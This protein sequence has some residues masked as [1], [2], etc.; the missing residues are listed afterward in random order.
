MYHLDEI[1]QIRK[2]G[3]PTKH[4][5]QDNRRYAP[6]LAET[7]DFVSYGY[8]PKA[9]IAPFYRAPSATIDDLMDYI[10]LI[11]NENH[12]GYDPKTNTWGKPDKKGYDK[13]NVGYGID[14]NNN[15]FLMPE[16]RD[17][18]YRISNNRERTIRAKT[19]YKLDKNYNN[20]LAE[21]I[22]MYPNAKQPSKYKQQLMYQ[23]L[24]KSPGTVAKN[25]KRHL[26]KSFMTGTDKEFENAILEM[27]SRT[28]RSTSPNRNILIL[29]YSPIK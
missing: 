10:E 7:D 20:R 4:L 13:Y 22:A 24:Y 8:K 1:R 19:I 18:S 27:Q 26:S 3:G 14:R 11:E 28:Q 5:Y 21:G 25:F 23:A 9:D 16:E 6:V 29:K 2:T 17:T 12:V 15:E